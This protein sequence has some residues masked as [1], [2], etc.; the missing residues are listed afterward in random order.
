MSAKPRS[1]PVALTLIVTAIFGLS[2]CATD[3][4]PP[5]RFHHY[6]PDGDERSTTDSRGARSAETYGD[7]RSTTDS[8]RAPSAGTY[9]ATR[10]TGYSPAEQRLRQDPGL[11]SKSSAQGCLAGAVAVALVTA[12]ITR[13]SRN[14]AI[15]AA[16]GCVAGVG[17]NAYVQNQRARYHSNEQQ[18]QATLADLRQDNRKL[19]AMIANSRAVMESDRRK[20]AAIDSAYRAKKISPAE[21]R[22]Q[23]RRVEANRDQVRDHLKSAREKETFWKGVADTNAR[24]GA[25]SA[26]VDA[27]IAKFREQ[28]AALEEE[29]RLQNELINASPAAG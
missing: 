29:Y 7:E 2:A 12:L 1:N 19:S 18:L 16:A 24:Q 11:L 28:R 23:M 15:G 22:A 20:I 17:V 25:S 3:P 21:A 9:G 26:Q 13:D 27:E 8:R 5:H 14:T 4:S 6:R 10:T